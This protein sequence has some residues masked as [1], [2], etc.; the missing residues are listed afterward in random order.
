[1]CLRRGFTFIE[2]LIALTIFALVSLGIYATFSTGLNAWRRGEDATRLQQEARWALDKIAQEL[3]GAALYN[4]GADYPELGSFLG[5]ENKIS[6]LSLIYSPASK[7]SEIKKITY[8]LEVPDYGEIHKT[9]VGTHQEKLSKIIVNYEENQ[10]PLES[11]QRKEE[12]LLQALETKEVT[13]VKSEPVTNLVKSGGLSFSYAFKQGAGDEE[14]TVWK[15][16]WE[17]KT[18]LP[19]GV[20]ITLIL[21]NPKNPKEEAIFTKTV[22]LEQGTIGQISEEQ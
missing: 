11:L 12:T 21:Q 8:S 13:P 17:D 5:G 7:I 16:A 6:F 3:R 14:V 18:K 1:M 10:A 15:A 4:Y 19:R 2:L 20:K 22:F 9:V